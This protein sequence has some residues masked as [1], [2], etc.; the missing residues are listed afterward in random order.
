MIERCD[1]VIAADPPANLAAI[2]Y[3]KAPYDLVDWS[4]DRKLL[5]R[6]V[7][8]NKTDFVG[9]AALVAEKAAGSPWRFVSMTLDEAGD[10]QHA[11]RGLEP[12]SARIVALDEMRRDIST[13]MQQDRQREV[14]PQDLHQHRR[15]AE[16]LDEHRGRPSRPAVGRLPRQADQQAQAEAGHGADRK[17]AQRAQRADEQHVGGAEAFDRAV[18]D[19]AEQQEG[20]DE[21]GAGAAGSG[22]Q[23]GGQQAQRVAVLAVPPV[24]LHDVSV[25][26]HLKALASCW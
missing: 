21:R 25:E 18:V 1:L 4:G 12:Q 15:V 9:K 17:Q 19:G 3:G 10:A 23:D 6:F 8:L 11:R 14:E 26:R 13:Q 16:E 22:R 5:D 24:V 2:L 7:D 20:E